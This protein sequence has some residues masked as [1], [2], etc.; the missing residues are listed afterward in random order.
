[1]ENKTDNGN[2]DGPIIHTQVEKIKKEFEKIRQPSLQQP[3]M[4]RVLSEIKRRQRSR[5]P[6]GLGER[7][8]S[9]GN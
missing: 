6:L 2:E 5:S 7:S 8:I 3:E 4:R 1:M 9:V